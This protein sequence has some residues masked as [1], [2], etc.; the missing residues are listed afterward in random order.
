[1]LLA[2]AVAGHN[3]AGAVVLVVIK[4]EVWQLVD[5]PLIQ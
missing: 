5:Q 3:K 2:V 1:L 4:Q